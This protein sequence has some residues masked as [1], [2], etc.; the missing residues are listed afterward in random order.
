MSDI[1]RWK[2]ILNCVPFIDNEVGVAETQEA[3]S[4][5]LAEIARLTA[6]VERLRARC[7]TLARLVH[8]YRHN[9]PLGHQPHMIASEADKAL[10]EPTDAQQ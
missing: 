6:E 5:M 4:Q 10:K 2:K 3:M 8:R 1:E 7:D 9:V